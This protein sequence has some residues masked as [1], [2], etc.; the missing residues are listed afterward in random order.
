MEGQLNILIEPLVN[1]HQAQQL[2]ALG[3]E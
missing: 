1:E 2:T 3:D